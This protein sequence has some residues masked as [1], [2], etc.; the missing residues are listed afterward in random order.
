MMKRLPL[1]TFVFCPGKK[2]SGEPSIMQT[3]RDPLLKWM[4][5]RALFY[6]ITKKGQYFLTNTMC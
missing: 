5:L 4:A 6:V 2:I 3:Y 1:D